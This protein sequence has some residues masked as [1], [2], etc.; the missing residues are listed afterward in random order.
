MS[1]ANSAAKKRRAGVVETPTANPN[2]NQ[3]VGGAT[4]PTPPASGLT[5]HQVV[6]LFDKRLLTLEKTVTEFIQAYMTE[7]EEDT[8]GGG[9]AGAAAAQEAIQ[10][11]A[12][13]A[14]QASKDMIDEFGARFEI[15]AEEI[16]NLKNTVMILQTYTLSVNK[17]LL[18]SNG[19]FCKIPNIAINK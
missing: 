11:A 12:Q 19:K 1:A 3:N 13:A 8:E 7:E 2:P 9:N 5:I 14:T 6:A 17:M 18:E 10:A 15:L 16:D 4:P